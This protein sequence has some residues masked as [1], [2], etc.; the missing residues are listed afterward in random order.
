MK[1]FLMSCVLSFCCVLTSQAVPLP[2]HGGR[3]LRLLDVYE[4]L[5]GEGHAT[6]EAVAAPPVADEVLQRLADF[7]RHWIEPPLAVGDDLRP[8]AGRWLAL[9]G[10][11]AQI[12]SVERWLVTA[13]ARRTDLLQFDVRFV[14]VPAKGFDSMLRTKL[15]PVER[16]DRVTWEKV[17]AAAAAKDVLAAALASGATNVT[18]CRLSVSPLQCGYASVARETSYVADFTVTTKED[19]WIAEPLID[20]V[21]DGVKTGV[22][23]CVLPNGTIGVSCEVLWQDLVQ[24]IP[25]VMVSVGVGPEVKIQLPR[26]NN[27][28]LRQIARLLDGD[29]IV[30]AAQRV[31]GDYLV[32]VVQ[33][34]GVVQPES[35]AREDQRA[36]VEAAR[37]KARTSQAMDE[38]QGECLVRWARPGRETA[39]PGFP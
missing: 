13:R 10:S 34:V 15:V 38:A 2:D 1:P 5:G 17:I 3:Q 37:S 14:V 26:T 27:G 36:N 31:G 19:C 22:V 20:V 30:L 11:A 25:E 28:R 8:L 32:A 7:L 16:G 4:L 35:E 33:M 9:V 18:N 29:A 21:W 6:D 39:E 23:A 12:A 24:P